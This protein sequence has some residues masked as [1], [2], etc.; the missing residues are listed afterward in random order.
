MGYFEHVC[1]LCGVSFA[2]AR[3]RRADEPE[4]ASWS[5]TGED[6]VTVDED[7]TDGVCGEDSGC[8][9]PGE[10]EHIAGPGCVS[11]QGY[12]GHRISLE[13]MKGCRKVQCLVKKVDP[14]ACWMVEDGDEGFEIEGKYFL[15]GVGDGS[16]DEGPLEDLEPVRHG[17][18]NVLLSNTVCSRRGFFWGGGFETRRNQ[19]D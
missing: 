8:S 13:E 7:M 17:V 11:E 14:D 18:E 6:F 3:L 10:G 16:P 1:Q 15:S 4:D 9:P 12:S 2:I 5:Y 19:S